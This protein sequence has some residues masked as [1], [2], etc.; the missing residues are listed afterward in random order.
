VVLDAGRI[1]QVGRPIDVYRN[2]VNRFVAGFIGSPQ[3]NLLEASVTEAGATYG[4]L[5][6]PLTP[7]QRAALTG[8]TVVLGVRPEDWRL[9]ADGGLEVQVAVVEELGSEA[10]LY[11]TDP[12]A[13]AITGKPIVARAE[14]LSGT[15]AGDRVHLVPRSDRVHVFDAGTGARI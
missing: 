6:V 4:D 12:S 8:S 14:G 15:Q 11:G 13:D 3:M 7:A 10:F 9:E 1:Q 5:T 2:P